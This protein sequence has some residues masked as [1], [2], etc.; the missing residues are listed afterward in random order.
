MD[1]RDGLIEDF[2]FKYLELLQ[3]HQLRFINL[4][5]NQQILEFG[6]RPYL[7]LDTSIGRAIILSDPIKSISTSFL[8]HL[9]KQSNSLLTAI[10]DPKLFVRYED[11]E[12]YQLIGDS[13]LFESLWKI[14]PTC[15]YEIIPTLIRILEIANLDVYQFHRN[16]PHS[17]EF[18]CI[19]T[20]QKIKGGIFADEKSYRSF[21]KSNA[22]SIQDVLKYFIEGKF[23][24]SQQVLLYTEELT[25]YIVKL[26]ERLND[27]CIKEAYKPNVQSAVAKILKQDGF[28][29]RLK[30]SHPKMLK[31]QIDTK[32]QR[33]YSHLTFMCQL[34]SIYETLN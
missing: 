16:R 1:Y 12:H 3:K 7:K 18:Y 32:L 9:A 13:I 21:I 22:K 26:S 34:D 11:E 23:C 25:D 24:S 2:D 14:S 20:G 29:K 5:D 27:N 31:H 28:S 6:E 19:V 33:K 30:L 8:P 17:A 15:Y 4:V 10:V